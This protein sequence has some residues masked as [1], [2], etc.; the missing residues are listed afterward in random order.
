MQALID[1]YT[2]QCLESPDISTVPETYKFK[3]ISGIFT[4]SVVVSQQNILSLNQRV[5]QLLDEFELLDENWDQ[6]DALKPSVKAIVNARTITRI[7]SKHGQPVYHTAPG[8]NGE[9][10]LDIRNRVKNKSFE[11]IFYTDRAVAVTFPEEGQPKQIS[12]STDIL[13][14]LLKWLNSN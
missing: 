13:P 9:I 11:L 14:D 5:L 7:L 6:D 3:H 8:P 2:T 4:N 1:N 10:L 12:F